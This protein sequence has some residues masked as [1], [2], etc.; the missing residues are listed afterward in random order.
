MTAN[1]MKRDEFTIGEEFWCGGRRWRCTDVGTRVIV[2]LCLEPREIV[3]TTTD[4]R[5]NRTT[6]Q[7][8]A[9]D[10]SWFTGPPYAVNEVVFDE[11]DIPACT[12]T[13]A[14]L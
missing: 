11:N 3:E 5:G 7:L 6:R 8:L 4:D 10:P 12:R 13:P 14:G 9:G 2:A 1:S